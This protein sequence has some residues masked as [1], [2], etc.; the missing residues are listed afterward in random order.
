[1]TGRDPSDLEMPWRV[2]NPDAKSHLY[3]T[4]SV[5]RGA[6]T[7]TRELHVHPYF[8]DTARQYLDGVNRIERE[9]A[10]AVREL[11]DNLRHERTR[12]ATNGGTRYTRKRRRAD[13]G[14]AHPHVFGQPAEVTSVG[15]LDVGQDGRAIGLDR[16]HVL[17]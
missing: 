9:V 11:C 3:D 4:V 16:S 5:R 7:T 1:M 14:P 10:D 15:G 8:H 6:K 12:C 17:S 13:A 2:G